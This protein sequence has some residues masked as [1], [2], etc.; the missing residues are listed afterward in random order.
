M[1]NFKPL[2]SASNPPTL[3][4]GLRIAQTYKG[5][6]AKVTP[7]GIFLPA[8]DELFIYGLTSKV[9]SDRLIDRLV[10]W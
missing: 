7:V 2:R 3:Y 4:Q 8:Y 1:I 10:E 6:E 9:T 5:E